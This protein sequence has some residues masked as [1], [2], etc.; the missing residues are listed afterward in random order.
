MPQSVWC[1]RDFWE[2]HYGC[3]DLIL[4]DAHQLYKMHARR[5]HPRR[6][7]DAE[8]EAKNLNMVWQEIQRRFHQRMNPRL[9][10][11][12]RK[13][14]PND[15]L[16]C[17]PGHYR[18][19]CP[20]VHCQRVFIT[21]HKNKIYCDERHRNAVAVRK[22]WLKNFGPKRVLRKCK[23]PRCGRLF[24]TKNHR[25][26][27]HSKQCMTRDFLWHRRRQNREAEAIRLKAYWHSP[28][29]KAWYKEYSHRPEVMERRRQL[30][31]TRDA[32]IREEKLKLKAKAES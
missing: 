25:K 14:A 6:D 8:E 17:P 12:G 13:H 27:F 23:N 3:L 29:G 31:R 1:H 2:H 7:T 18:R 16:P 19:V 32:R 22:W 24:W 9:V 26:V 11:S 21:T 15:Q 4:Y 28:K 20:Y 30:R 10:M 5:V